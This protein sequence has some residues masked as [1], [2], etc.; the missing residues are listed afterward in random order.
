MVRGDGRPPD[1]NECRINCYIKY[2]LGLGR[3]TTTVNRE[4]Q[5]LGQSMRRAK[6]KKLIADIP[7]SEKFSEKHNG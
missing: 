5:Y 6:K 4:L 3:S 1:V 2:R 7:L